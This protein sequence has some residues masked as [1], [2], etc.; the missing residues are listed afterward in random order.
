MLYKAEPLEYNV[1]DTIR[2]ILSSP[3]HQAFVE[4]VVEVE[5]PFSNLGGEI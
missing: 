4:P 2:C 1:P 5:G 3:A